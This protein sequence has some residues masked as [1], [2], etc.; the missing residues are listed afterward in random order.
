MAS[1][2]GSSGAVGQ[3]TCRVQPLDHELRQFPVVLDDQ[4]THVTAAT[5]HGGRR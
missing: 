1:L 5:F 2:G 3:E 4:D